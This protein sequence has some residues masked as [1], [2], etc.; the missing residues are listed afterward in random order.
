MSAVM[1]TLVARARHRGHHVIEDIP[2]HEN[3]RDDVECVLINGKLVT[4]TRVE[5]DG[6]VDY[7]LGVVEEK[8]KEI[9]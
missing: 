5:R 7:L 2:R 3:W 1:D 6:D 9:T 4:L 8:L